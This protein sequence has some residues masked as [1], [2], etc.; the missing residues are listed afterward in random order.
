MFSFKG[1]TP[2]I[3]NS[4]QKT[5]KR[6]QL[7]MTFPCVKTVLATF[8]ISIEK[9]DLSLKEK[10]KILWKKVRGFVDSE[11]MKTCHE[12]VTSKVNTR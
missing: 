7:T 8:L 9:L 3:Q 4:N 1:A 2:R 12:H 11:F 5:P 10:E 6:Y